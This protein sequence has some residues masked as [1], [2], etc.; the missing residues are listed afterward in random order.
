MTERPV[1]A[2]DRLILRPWRDADREALGA[3]NADPEVMAHFPAPL[4]RA[5]SDA[6]LER[7]RG[8]FATLGFG[9]W[10]VT[11]APDGPLLGL[12]GLGAPRFEAHF[13][14]CIEVAWRL[15]RA[16]WGK[17]YASE[18]ARAAL[19]FGFERAGLDEIVAMTLPTN[20]RSQAVMERLGMTRDPAD[21]FDHPNVPEGHA[22]R[23]H[24]LYRLTRD[25]WRGG[26]EQQ[27]GA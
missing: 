22:M 20:R 18:A 3:L 2:T 4:D 8:Q 21:D 13:T 10:A 7:M 15:G 14:P 1:L 11:E 23:R 17:G 26:Q 19:V 5:A 25:A 24:L 6:M 12:V 16:H 9:F 27:Q